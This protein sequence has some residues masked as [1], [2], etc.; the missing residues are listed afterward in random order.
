MFI[1]KRIVDF[2]FLFLLLALILAPVSPVHA[3]AIRYAAPSVMG[4][5]D[6]SSWADACT[7]QTAL[8]GAMSGNVI[9]VKMGV[10]YPGVAGDRSATF[11]LK[12]GVA[13]Y[14]GFAGTESSGDERDWQINLTILSGDI[15]GNDTN[16]DGNF[17]AE[18]TAD[19]LGSNAYH[20]VT[21]DSTVDTAVLDGFVITA[22]QANGGD[23]SDSGGGMYNDSSSPT[24]MNVIF[25]GNSAY[26]RGGGMYNWYSSP[27][28]TDVTFNGNSITSSE[29]FNSSGGGMYNVVSNP[30]LTNVTFNGNS[31]YYSGGGMYNDN[32]ISTLTN[33]AFRG[34][35]AQYGGG[36]FNW[37]S[38]PTLTNVTFS[39][40][41]FT[42]S[43]EFD[44]SGGGMYNRSSSPTLTNVTFSGNSANSNGGGM[45]NIGS[46]N[47][48]LTNVIMWGDNAL[49]GPEIYNDN[50]D[51]SISYSDI[52]GCGGSGGGWQ[53]S[54]GTDDGG[55]I[56]ADPLFVDA[57][58]PD[59]LV[60]TADDNLRLG[61]D[62]PAIDAGNDDALPPGVTTDLDGL[63]RFADGN[64]DDDPV[65]DMGAYEAGQM[66]CGV[67]EGNTYT[68]NDQSSVSIEITTLDSELN[69]LYVDEMELNHPNATAGI[70]RGRY[71]L[72]RGLQSDK[73]TNATGFS[74]TLTLPTSFTPDD[75]DKLCRYPGNLGGAGWD[76]AADSHTTD[77]I[78]RNDVS[79][80]SDWAVGNNVGPTA[81][82]LQGFQVSSAP[83]PIVWLFSAALAIAVFFAKKRLAKP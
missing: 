72:I 37:S 27:I 53:S 66:I 20:V 73:Q 7:L 33:V 39:G 22:G 67:S 17:I 74:V 31:A 4:S 9:W 15:D 10:H 44:S 78:T 59:N 14:G 34:N 65:V 80:F 63:P 62:S 8:S 11:T 45:Y 23:P 28:L 81:V 60:G 16:T 35:T 30:T 47:P 82:K 68:F 76:C 70:Q 83:S 51:A 55:N 46:S 56:D 6:C 40:N 18:T 42:G 61:F 24:L 19:I 5:G 12:N 26:H 54:C 57:D 64:G 71:W 2:F 49:Y 3:A 13:V 36:M 48:T 79:A 52:Q 77:S 41:S 75:S 29:V 1:P 21:S 43:E 50:S 32:S 38:S 58:G 25:S 69:C